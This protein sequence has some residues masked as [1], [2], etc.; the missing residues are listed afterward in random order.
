MRCDG[1]GKNGFGGAVMMAGRTLASILAVSLLAAP[2]TAPCR[3]AD[4]AVQVRKE[5]RASAPVTLSR[6]EVDWLNAMERQ[7]A[8]DVDA[9][10]P[11][12]R[13]K[14]YASA[15]KYLKKAVDT[16]AEMERF[17]VARGYV[18]ASI[19]RFGA[20][21]GLTAAYGD[22]AEITVYANDPRRAAA[23]PGKVR[24]L[25]ADARRKLVIAQ[26]KFGT[27]PP[28]AE[29]CG[30]FIGALDEF[31]RDVQKALRGN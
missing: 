8:Q 25:L 7:W 17:L 16:L 3:A 15:Q 30:R 22:M 14:D 12:I 20:M 13:Q 27:V 2:A 28:L 31:E 18:V 24:A 19:D 1:L 5:E 6:D 26:A 4:Q 9:A 10:V 23:N 21:E 11:F 29:L